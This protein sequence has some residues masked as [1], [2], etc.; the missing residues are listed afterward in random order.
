MSAASEM[1][2]GTDVSTG[3]GRAVLLD[4]RGREAG[5]GFPSPPELF[6]FFAM[7]NPVKQ[8]RDRAGTQTA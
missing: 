5:A 6:D 8:N 7:F 1:A 2:I 4:R 3:P